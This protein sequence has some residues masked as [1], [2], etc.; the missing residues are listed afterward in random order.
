MLEDDQVDGDPES[1]ELKGLPQLQ[2][3]DKHFKNLKSEIPTGYPVNNKQAR[4]KSNSTFFAELHAR[5]V[6]DSI[7]RGHLR[8]R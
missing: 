4:S 3:A 1:G 5:V 7:A 8:G 6:N 2:D